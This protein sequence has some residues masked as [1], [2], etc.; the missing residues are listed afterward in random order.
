VSFQLPNLGLSEESDTETTQSRTILDEIPV[1]IIE[2]TETS[3]SENELLNYQKNQEQ[4]LAQKNYE[5]QSDLPAEPIIKASEKAKTPTLQEKPIEI[6]QVKSDI[7][8]QPDPKA[9]GFF[10]KHLLLGGTIVGITTVV[11][12]YFNPNFFQNVFSMTSNDSIS[13]TSD[14]VSNNLQ[15]PID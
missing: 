6:M 11:A 1:N 3:K 2:T 5:Q 7:N 4:E 15:N 13:E 9:E 12:R 10:Y 8:L 14:S